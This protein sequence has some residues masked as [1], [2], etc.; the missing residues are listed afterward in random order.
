MEIRTGLLG[1]KEP[2]VVRVTRGLIELCC[3][4]KKPEVVPRPRLT[5]I[6]YELLLLYCFLYFFTSRFFRCYTEPVIF[7]NC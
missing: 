2:R 3:V 5:L 7:E 6:S 4:F 1:K